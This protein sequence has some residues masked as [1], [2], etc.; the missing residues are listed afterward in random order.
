MGGYRL[1]PE[2]NLGYQIITNTK[3]QCFCDLF[4]YFQEQLENKDHVL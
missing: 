2:N 3:G 4:L 1:A